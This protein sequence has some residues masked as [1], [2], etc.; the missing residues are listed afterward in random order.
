MYLGVDGNTKYGGVV[1]TGH[2][3]PGAPPAH[4][5]LGI[6]PRGSSATFIWVARNI[7]GDNHLWSYDGRYKRLSPRQ[8]KRVGHKFGDY[9]RVMYPKIV[10]PPPRRQLGSSA[11]SG[12]EFEEL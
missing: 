7:D 12:D 1:G 10:M 2:L 5:D 8:A 3:Q 9:F 4:V 6:G 11:D